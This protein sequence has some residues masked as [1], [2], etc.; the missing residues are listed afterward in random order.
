MARAAVSQQEVRRDYVTKG[1]PPTVGFAF[2]ELEQSP[3][4]S[5]RVVACFSCSQPHK[6]HRRTFLGH[7]EQYKP[8]L[9]GTALQHGVVSRIAC[10]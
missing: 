2:L 3:G 7:M 4:S 1:E 8:A 5:N 9:L 6:F 10:A